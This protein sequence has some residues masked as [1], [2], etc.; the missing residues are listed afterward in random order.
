MYF[1]APNFICNKSYVFDY[2]LF[3]IVNQYLPL[4]IM[5]TYS[6][7]PQVLVRLPPELSPVGKYPY[8]PLPLG[9]LIH[10]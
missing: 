1:G 10:T 3:L 5:D 7:L 6:N 4:Y 8:C 2:M 9:C